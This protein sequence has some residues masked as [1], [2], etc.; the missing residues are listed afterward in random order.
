[1]TEIAELDTLVSGPAPD[2]AAAKRGKL[3]FGTLALYG[4][5][6]LVENATTPVLA[7]SLFYLSALCGLSGSEAGL[8]A[9]ITLVVDSLCDPWWDRFPTTAV[10]AMAGAI[11]SCC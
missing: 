1:M 11:R 8:V 7:L 2:P 10:R 3:G 6:T 5:G 4:V 9:M